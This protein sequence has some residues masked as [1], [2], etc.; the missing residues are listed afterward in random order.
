[1]KAAVTIDPSNED[2]DRGTA[3]IARSDQP[4]H[5]IGRVATPLFGVVIDHAG[6]PPM[7]PDP[8]IS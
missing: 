4:E 7:S 5:A 6:C 2:P 3:T 1:V 8:V